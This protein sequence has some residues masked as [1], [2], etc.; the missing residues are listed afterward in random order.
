LK[1]QETKD[2]KQVKCWIW[3]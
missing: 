3:A 1:K 2:N